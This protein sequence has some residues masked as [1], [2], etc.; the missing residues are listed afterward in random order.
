MLPDPGMANYSDKTAKALE[1]ER[2]AAI[3][4]WRTEFCKPFA[5]DDVDTLQF[6]S[7]KIDELWTEH[8]KQL[9]DHRDK[10]EDD[11]PVWPQ[12]D[13][14][15]VWVTTTTEKDVV[16]ATGIFNLNAKTASAYRRLKMA[17]DYWC[18]LGF[19]PIN[20]SEDLPSRDEFLMEMMLLLSGDVLDVQP[21]QK[22]LFTA[23]YAEERR[24]KTE[25]VSIRKQG[26]LIAPP[27]A[28]LG[29]M[30]QQ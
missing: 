1:P 15:A 24:G 10:T 3:K 22:E 16:R 5:P 19:W 29:L 14:K 13:E 2:F 9:N 18:S 20:K 7:G 27:Q 28:E 12:Q 6:L 8:A 4:K 17:M 26:E 11:I 23:E 30:I 25:R 21:K